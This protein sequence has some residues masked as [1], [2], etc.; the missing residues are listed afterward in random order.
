MKIPS[1]TDLLSP[2]LAAGAPTTL[3]EIGRTPD[4]A[5]H[6]LRC[7]RDIRDR[8][9]VLDLGHELGVLPGSIDSVLN[10]AGV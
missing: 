9:T 3:R 4:D 10:A 8:Y 1:P 5:R 7:A 2:L 6:A